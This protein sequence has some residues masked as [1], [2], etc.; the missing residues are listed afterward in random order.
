MKLGKVCQNL[1][2]PLLCGVRAVSGAGLTHACGMRWEKWESSMGEVGELVERYLRGCRNA[3]VIPQPRRER[4]GRL[5]GRASPP[6]SC[7]GSLSSSS[8]GL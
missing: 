1:G 3:R 5:T 6:L 7:P 4:L 8:R 2:H